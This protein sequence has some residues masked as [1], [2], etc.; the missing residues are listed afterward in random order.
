MFHHPHS[1]LA[2]AVHMAMK[3]GSKQ[4]EY[5]QELSLSHTHTP[6]KTHDQDACM[7]SQIRQCQTPYCRRDIALLI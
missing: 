3:Y 5:L 1:L 2:L 4:I 7:V 6:C